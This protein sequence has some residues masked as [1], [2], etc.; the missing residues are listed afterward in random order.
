MSKDPC[1]RIQTVPDKIWNDD[2]P[3]KP[4]PSW[5]YDLVNVISHSAD[6]APPTVRVMKVACP[7]TFGGRWFY[8]ACNKKKC[9]RNAIGIIMHEDRVITRTVVIH[10]MAHYLSSVRNK[11]RAGQHDDRFFAIVEPMYRQLR[12]KLETAKLVEGSYPATWE[13]GN[14]WGRVR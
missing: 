12:V 6:V 3:H 7:T 9:V 1:A 11:D 10:E 4:V 13:K 5:I 14:T 2:F 8:N